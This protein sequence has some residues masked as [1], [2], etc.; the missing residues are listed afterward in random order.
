MMDMR[1]SI[2]EAIYRRLYIP[3]EEV[4]KYKHSFGEKTPYGNYSK[5]TREMWLVACVA[6]VKQ[7]CLI[8][9]DKSECTYEQFI[10]DISQLDIYHA[11]KEKYINNK[12]GF[13]LALL[14]SVPLFLVEYFDKRFWEE[15]VSM[16]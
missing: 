9:T 7:A 16:A 8:V 3:L 6:S 11:E 15:N 1:L 5:I 4:H 13:F 12:N 2:N 14:N 10:Q